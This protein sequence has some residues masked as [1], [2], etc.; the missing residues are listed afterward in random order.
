MTVVLTKTIEIED[1]R[2]KKV[3]ISWD[4]KTDGVMIVPTVFRRSPIPSE[5]LLEALRELDVLAR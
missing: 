1:A 4:E 2:G 5:A 3:K